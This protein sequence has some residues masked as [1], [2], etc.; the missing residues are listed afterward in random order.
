MRTTLFRLAQYFGWTEILRRD[1]QFLSFPE[2]DG[3]AGRPA[4]VGLAERFLSD[5]PRRP[6]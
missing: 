2:D 5:E 4:A 1:I 3:H 6:R